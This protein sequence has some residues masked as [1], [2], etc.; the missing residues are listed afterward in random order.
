MKNIEQ[1]GSIKKGYEYYYIAELINKTQQSI[2]Y[3]GR[4]DREIFN[5]K[6][7]G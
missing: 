3:I 4:D 7:K 1:I 6:N 5:I 2:I